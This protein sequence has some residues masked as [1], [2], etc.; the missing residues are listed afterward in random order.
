MTI[1]ELIAKC[2]EKPSFYITT[3]EGEK[4]VHATTAEDGSRAIVI[5]LDEIAV[6]TVT[7]DLDTIE[8]LFV[9]RLQS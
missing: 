5:C 9:A 3:S 7:E 4:V 2:Q 1:E 8:S 6:E